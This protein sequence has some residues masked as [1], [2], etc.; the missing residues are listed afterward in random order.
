MKTRITQQL[1]D[2]EM[3]K[4]KF[5]VDI[6]FDTSSEGSA[7]GRKFGNNGADGVGVSISPNVGEPLKPLARIASGGEMS[8]VMLAVK[9]ITAEIGQYS[10]DDI[11]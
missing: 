9:S 1:D 7:S 11:R 10:G 8:R 3:E 6:Q 2:T 5:K 4:S